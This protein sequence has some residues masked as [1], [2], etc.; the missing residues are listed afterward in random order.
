[1]QVADVIA[2]WGHEI[3]VG[4]AVDRLRCSA[5]RTKRI[6]EYRIIYAGG[7]ALA[8]HGAEQGPQKLE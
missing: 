1:M 3:T 7:S 2:K 8:M 6:K 4:E 5:C